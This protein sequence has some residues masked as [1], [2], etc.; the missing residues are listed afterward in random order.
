MF[1]GRLGGST[2]GLR[3]VWLVPP[4]GLEPATLALPGPALSFELRGPT[5]SANKGRC[6]LDRRA[7]PFRLR[8]TKCVRA[9]DGVILTYL[10]HTINPLRS[11]TNVTCRDLVDVTEFACIICATVRFRPNGRF[12]NG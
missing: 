10:T 9:S 2:P 4:A 1:C 12:I 3:T 7:A 5:R 11:H 8:G 6:V